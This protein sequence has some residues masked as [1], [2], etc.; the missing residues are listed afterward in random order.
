M[1]LGDTIA[2][3]IGILDDIIVAEKITA[4]CTLEAWTGQNI[5]GDPT[6]ATAVPFEAVVELRSDL[7]TN[8]EGLEVLSKTK[9]TITRP[10]AATVAANRDNPIDALDKITLPDGTTGPIITTAGLV[11]GETDAPYMLEVWL[12]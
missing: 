5:D 9:L 7:K 3:G 1:S 8:A 11:A 6:F 12:G 4:G 2:L 10:I